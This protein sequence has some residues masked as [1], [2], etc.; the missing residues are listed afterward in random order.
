M[1]AFSHGRS[2]FSNFSEKG[3][4]TE[5]ADN[6]TIFISEKF[7]FYKIA[8]CL[9]F[10][11]ICNYNKIILATSIVYHSLMSHFG[12]SLCQHQFFNYSK[13]HK[14]KESASLTLHL[15]IT[16][17][18]SSAVYESTIYQTHLSM[19]YVQEPLYNKNIIV[20]VEL[21][22]I[23]GCNITCVIASTALPCNPMF[24]ELCQWTS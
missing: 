1:V 10:V 5:N 22:E 21:L 9:P 11:S 14:K 7:T 24:W 8:L 16:L 15:F 12:W 18:N 23:N 20:A 19:N 2:I 17:W 4:K 3:S 13:I 6:F